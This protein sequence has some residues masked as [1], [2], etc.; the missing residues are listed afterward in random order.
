VK[1]AQIFPLDVIIVCIESERAFTMSPVKVQKPRV[2]VLADADAVSRECLQQFISAANN[3]I[4]IKGVFHFAISGGHTPKGFFELLAGVPEARSLE[5][6]KMHVFWVDERYVPK[7]SPMSNYKLAADTFLTKVPIPEQNI[8]PIPTDC[9][10]F[11]TSARE[12]EKTIRSIFNLKQN[13]LP[14]FDFI[15]LGMGA[16]GHTGS[17]FPNFYATFDTKDIA[18]V[19]YLLDQKLPDQ[20]V[21][22]I[23]LTHPVLKAASQIVVLV[24]GPEK[25]KTLRGV[26]TGPPDEVQY[27]IH[28]LWPALD[29]ILWLVDASAAKLL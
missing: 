2:K 18:C 9:E 14:V 3:A 13:R 27:P 24:T 12:Y 22:R 25:A 29:K 8:H 19:V 4:K 23:T 17:M 11:E 7:D 20:Q 26:I 16:D 15:L 21:N 28:T 5:W 6:D 10:D 1:S